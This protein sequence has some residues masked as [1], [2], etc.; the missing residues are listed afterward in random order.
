MNL[1]CGLPDLLHRGST[2]TRKNW[3][4]LEEE[5]MIWK[6][7]Q[8]VIKPIVIVL[9]RRKC[10]ENQQTTL[11]KGLQNLIDMMEKKGLKFFMATQG[12]MTSFYQRE[13]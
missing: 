3:A 11:N 7:Y 1:K 10:L 6:E 5:C 12:P 4:D 13:G 2:C 8:N 9:K